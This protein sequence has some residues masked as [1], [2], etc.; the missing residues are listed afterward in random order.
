MST[1]QFS[2]SM[3]S[4]QF[5]SDSDDS[6]L[7]LQVSLRFSIELANSMKAKKTTQRMIR[8]AIV[9]ATT[10]QNFRSKTPKSKCNQSL[11][12]NWEEPFKRS[13]R[14]SSCKKKSKTCF[15]E[16]ENVVA[17]FRTFR[18]KGARQIGII[19]LPNS[20]Q[21]SLKLRVSTQQI[22]IEELLGF[23]F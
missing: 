18:T 13:M 6:L 7:H 1:T 5:V 22:L 8:L 12:K 17:T 16:F 15:L 3:I 19:C 14:F 2:W 21:I 9:L 11:D 20:R 4:V 23:S 10:N